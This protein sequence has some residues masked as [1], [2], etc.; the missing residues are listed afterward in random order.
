MRVYAILSKFP[1]SKTL[2]LPLSL[3]PKKEDSMVNTLV[4]L[5]MLKITALA[6]D[7]LYF[8][9]PKVQKGKWNSSLI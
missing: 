3:L 6:V 7:C 9:I 2:N 4:F 5:M 1:G 8:E